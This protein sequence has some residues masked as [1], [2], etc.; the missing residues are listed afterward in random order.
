MA[1]VLSVRNDPT[2]LD[3]FA[4]MPERRRFGIRAAE[5]KKKT[6]TPATVPNPHF[7]NE[8]RARVGRALGGRAVA[9]PTPSPAE[10]RRFAARAGSGS[11]VQVE[12][13]REMR[14]NPVAT[15]A[16]SWHCLR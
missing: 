9:A 10:V 3:S 1:A 12:S 13:L 15:A 5:A 8:G 14:L 4:A 2:A 7:R 11:T 6:K 16:H